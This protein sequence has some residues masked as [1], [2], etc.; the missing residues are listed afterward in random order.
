MLCMTCVRAGEACEHAEN[1]DMLQSSRKS[2]EIFV[3]SDRERSV[4]GLIRPPMRMQRMCNGMCAE[5]A[6]TCEIPVEE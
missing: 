6:R 2:D 3:L 1:I 4:T 5:E